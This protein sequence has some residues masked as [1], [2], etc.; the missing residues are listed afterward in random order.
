MN[1][2]WG[3]VSK[4]Q[5]NLCNS[6]LSG[7]TYVCHIMM[8][9]TIVNEQIIFVFVDRWLIYIDSQN[10]YLAREVCTDSYGIYEGCPA[11]FH[12]SLSLF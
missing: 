1:E 10:A 11:E 6:V 3:N 8:N 9:G 2:N 5:L 12:E 4:I 7:V